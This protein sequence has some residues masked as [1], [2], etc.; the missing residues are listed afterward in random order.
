MSNF[1]ATAEF[2]CVSVDFDQFQKKLLNFSVK[3]SWPRTKRFRIREGGS[4][5]ARG[6]QTSPVTWT[7]PA[8]GSKIKFLK[9]GF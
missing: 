4:F 1:G 2:L 3:T 6:D 7:C 5:N 8:F 9:T